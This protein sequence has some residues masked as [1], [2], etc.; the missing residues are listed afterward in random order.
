MSEPRAQAPELLIRLDP[1]LTDP[2]I[3][4]F[5]AEHLRDMHAISPP[6]SV[7]ALDMSKLRQPD[8]CFWTGWL[9]AA[10]PAS[11]GDGMRLVATAA[12]KRLDGQHAE[13]KSMRTAADLRGRGLARRMLAHVL[14]QARERGYT[15]LSLETGTQPF[16]E[17]ARQLYAR[18]GFQFCGPFGSYNLD[19]Y[20]CFMSLTL[21]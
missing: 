11:G 14:T 18:S 3:A 15:R 21:D 2:R 10:E 5:M 1:A 7:H 9:P 8:I 12:I 17:P 4:D 20:S 19:P 16:F 13:L 6:E